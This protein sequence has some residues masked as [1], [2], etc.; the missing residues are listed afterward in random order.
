MQKK[1][2]AN[3]LG[4][5]GIGLGLVELCAPRWLSR[6]I[7]AGQ[8]RPRTMRAF[9]LREIAAGIAILTRRQKAPG[10][11]A[12]AAGDLLDLVALGTAIRRGRRRSRS[13]VAL[14]AVIG[15]GIVDVLAATRAPGQGQTDAVP[16]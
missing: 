1:T 13:A 16:A 12:R 5:F 4:L 7:G 11:W 15:A 2:I 8:R 9:G 6:K 14:A 10:L 3:G